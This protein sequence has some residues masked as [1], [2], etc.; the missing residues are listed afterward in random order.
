MLSI[1]YQVIKRKANQENSGESVH[2]IY[3]L[4]DANTFY[5]LAQ[6]AVVFSGF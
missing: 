3:I 5:L 1:F 2:R 4:Q 6:E